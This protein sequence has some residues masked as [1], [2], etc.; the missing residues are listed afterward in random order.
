MFLLTL[1]IAAASM[2][3]GFA[4]GRSLAQ[5]SFRPIGPMH[6]ALPQARA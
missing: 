6:R 3:L 1:L 2:P 4:F 5:R